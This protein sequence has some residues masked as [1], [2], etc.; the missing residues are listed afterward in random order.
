MVIVTFKVVDPVIRDFDHFFV[1]LLRLFNLIQTFNGVIMKLNFLFKLFQAVGD[2]SR[3]FLPG[4]VATGQGS[5][6]RQDRD[7]NCFAHSV[8]SVHP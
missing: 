3:T 4:E 1:D 8:T 7:D 6:Q 5:D 2:Q